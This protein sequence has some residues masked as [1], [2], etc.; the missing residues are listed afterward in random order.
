M[1]DD[2]SVLILVQVSLEEESDVI[3]TNSSEIPSSER[4][5]VHIHTH[6]LYHFQYKA[7]PSEWCKIFRKAKN[8]T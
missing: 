4:T 3:I 6:L 8:V 5:L 1:K 2:I 7:S